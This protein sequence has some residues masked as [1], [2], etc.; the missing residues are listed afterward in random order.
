MK[1]FR[2]VILIGLGVVTG[3]ALLSFALLNQSDA[4]LDFFLFSPVSLPVWLLVL[5]CLGLG[6]VVPRFLRIGQWYQWRRERIRMAKRV[7]Q[8]EQEVVALRNIPLELEPQG[9]AEVVN[10]NEAVRIRAVSAIDVSDRNS[11]P[12]LLP[13]GS[14]PAADADDPE[15][16]T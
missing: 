8:L 11:G 13:S 10:P 16:T 2:R 7:S 9:T 5:V 1:S 6:W 3:V 12:P 4:T 15:M 14:D